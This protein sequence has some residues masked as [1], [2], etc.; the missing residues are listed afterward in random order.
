MAVTTPKFQLTFDIIANTLTLT[1]IST[2][3]DTDSKATYKVT[4]VT[5]GTV[6]GL[7][8]GWNATTPTWATPPLHGATV[9]VLV[10]SLPTVPA[11]QYKV[12]YWA[13]GDDSV[14]PMVTRYFTFDYESPVVS[15][16]MTTLCS[17]GQLISDDVTD[18]NKV[19]NGV[20]VVPTITFAHTVVKPAGSSYAGTL[21]TT[22]E[23]TRT[24]GSP[25]V[26]IWTRTW[27][28][29]L[30]T[31]LSY[32]MCDWSSSDP[33]V[34]ISDVVKGN[35]EE[36]VQCDAT[37]CALAQCY[38]NMFDRWI[39]SLTQ[40]FNYREDNRDKI[41]ACI[42]LFAQL[43]WFERCGT[44]TEETITALQTLLSGENCNCTTVS[45]AAS[46]PIVPWASIVGGGSSISTFVFHTETTIPT[47]ADG[48]DGDVWLNLT[49]YDLY[50]KSGGAWT[51]KGNI[52]GA[53]GAAGS[54]VQKVKVLISE[55]TSR[56]TP[57][58]NVETAISYAMA[59]NNSYFEWEGDYF[60]FDYD[61]LLAANDNGKKIKL[62]YDSDTM[63]EWQTDDLVTS[64]NDIVTVH[65]KITRVNNL[66]QHVKTWLTRAGHPGELYGPFYFRSYSKD[67]NTS[68]TVVL[69]GTNLAVS[70]SAGDIEGY[71]T[72]VK[73]YKRETELIA[74]GSG[75]SDGRGLVNQ[76]F[77]A[78]EGQTEFVVTD[79][80]ANSYYIPLID[81]VIQSTL[82]VTR[83]GNTF[84]TPALSA[85]QVLMIMN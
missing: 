46:E 69:M 3:W 11:G 27:Q 55:T 65:M 30:S 49:T 76:V 17:T 35:D 24:I 50:A 48:N 62:Y 12:E 42:G 44:D 60:E 33:T 63:L 45:D 41:I 7:G 10:G 85:G 8:S 70:P 74:G 58:S 4:H 78:T 1:D 80:T 82:V 5:S 15:I 29:Y 9:S 18:Y 47:G 81:N 68:K 37:I 26:P 19:Y 54:A 73:L 23:R 79:F 43:Q 14:M 31:T 36:F 75:A 38:K 64:D 83:S 13:F 16:N 52:K 39:A 2:G 6:I 53:T 71:A 51:L 34:Y 40:N 56:K 67:L 25:S 72:T 21:G 28:T 22:N 77:I 66:E 20:Q 57:A 61:V 32:K 59:V 84:T